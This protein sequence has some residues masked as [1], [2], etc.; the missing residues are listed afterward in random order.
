[1]TRVSSKN[2]KSTIISKRNRKKRKNKRER[3]KD[4]AKRVSIAPG[5]IH[6]RRN[7]EGQGQTN[8]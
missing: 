5:T 4:K 1:M 3:K 8:G 7:E 2:Y 6:E